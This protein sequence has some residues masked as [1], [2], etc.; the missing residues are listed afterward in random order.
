MRKGSTLWLPGIFPCVLPSQEHLFELETELKVDPLPKYCLYSDQNG[1]W[2]V[3]A[4]P[5]SPSSFNSR[6]AVRARLRGGPCTHRC[7]CA[8]AAGPSRV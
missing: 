2:R 4:I 7:A 1:Q 3:Q 6:R 5:Q 8:C